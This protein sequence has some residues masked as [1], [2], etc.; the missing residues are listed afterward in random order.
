M[1][2]F[3]ALQSLQPFSYREVGST[4]GQPPGGYDFDLTRTQLGRGRAVFQAACAA[5]KQWRM[6]PAPWTEIHPAHTPI[7]SGNV[8]VVLGRVFG[9]W[10]MNACRIVYVVEETEPQRSF[11]FAYG[12]LPG[13]VESGEERFTVQ[14]DPDDV[15]WYDLR[16]FS[17]PHYWP[18]RLCYRMTRRLQ[19]RFI[20]ESHASMQ[21]AVTKLLKPCRDGGA[22]TVR[23]RA[24]SLRRAAPL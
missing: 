24:R 3:R 11:G 22:A 21:Q 19:R 9:L 5:L 6:F 20:V 13:H 7:R 1:R 4:Q 12:T 2:T 14:W 16:A 10:W 15:V 17:R 18:V 23:E 8:V